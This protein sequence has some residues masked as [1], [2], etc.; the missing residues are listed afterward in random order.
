MLTTRYHQYKILYYMPTTENT[1]KV[2]KFIYDKYTNKDLNDDSLVQI[3]TLSFN[4]LGLKTIQ[5]F[6]KE[7][8]KTYNGVKKFSKNLVKINNLTFVKDNL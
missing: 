1:E 2:L 4:L 6:A 3:I 8:N 5:E 7:N